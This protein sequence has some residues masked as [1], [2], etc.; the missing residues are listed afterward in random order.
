MKQ[1]IFDPGVK[2]SIFSR[3]DAITHATK[4][5]WGKL[6]SAQMIRHLTEAAR[7][8]FG[9]IEMPDRSTELTRTVIK[10]QFLGNIKP[11]GRENGNIQ[12]FPEVDVVQSG[13]VVDDLETE[14]KRYKEIV[15]RLI[16]TPV[17]HPVH[18]V[19]GEMSREDWG[20]LAFAHADY[21]LT[22]FNN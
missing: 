3:V 10:D 4:G 21:H 15:E 16:D 22:Q 11:E 5:A 1:S 9:E 13:M 17:L 20:Y 7:M 19:F 12:T 6:S 2:E 18:T 8:A 14:K